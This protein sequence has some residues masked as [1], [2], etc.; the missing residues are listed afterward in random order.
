MIKVNLNQKVRMKIREARLDEANKIAVLLKQVSD[1][2]YIGR[3]DIFK[4]KT[5]T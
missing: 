2:H 1:I 5:N 3:P 4:E